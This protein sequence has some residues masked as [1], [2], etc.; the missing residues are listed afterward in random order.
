MTEET[1]TGNNTRLSRRVAV[2][3][4][5]VSPLPYMRRRVSRPTVTDRLG[6][7]PRYAADARFRN[8]AALGEVFVVVIPSCPSI[9]F[10]FQG[11][12]YVAHA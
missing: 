7:G 10:Y 11:Q 6:A 4:T 1:I 2:S 5:V 9:L 12:A 3:G 8:G